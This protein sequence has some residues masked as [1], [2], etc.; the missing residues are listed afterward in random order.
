MQTI[1]VLLLPSVVIP[2]W[3]NMMK[4]MGQIV[5]IE[6]KR[7]HEE[8]VSKVEDASKLIF[9]ANSSANNLAT[10]LG[11]I[12]QDKQPSFSDIRTKVAWTLFE[13]QL[14]LPYSTQASYI[15]L[16]GHL[17]S[18]F[19]DGGKRYAMY[20][21][22]TFPSN[23]NTTDAYTWYTQSVN[24]NTGQ[25]Y[26]EAKTIKPLVVVEEPWFKRAMHSPNGYA[27]LGFQWGANKKGEPDLFLD[28]ARLGQTGVISLGFSVKEI[29]GLFSGMDL[30]DGSLYM[31]TL[32]DH[33]KVLLEEIKEAKIKINGDKAFILGDNNDIFGEIPCKSNND[34]TK[35]KGITLDVGGKSLVFSC[36]QIDIA[37]IPSAYVLAF[38]SQGLLSEVHQHTKAALV[39]LILMMVAMVISIFA[40]VALVVRAAR[41]EVQLCA[42]YMRQMEKTAQ[43]ERKTMKQS[44]AFASASHDIRGYIACIKSLIGLSFNHVHPSSPLASNLNNM[45]TCAQ[46]LLGLVNSI[47]DF[48]KIEAGKMQLEETEFDLSQ[49]LENMA[50]LH[51]LVAMKN[52][53]EV[54]L[55]PCDG[56][57]MKFSHVKGDALKLK[58][59]L[60]NLLSNAVKFTSQGHISIRAWAKKPSLENSIIASNKN[61]LLNWLLSKFSY[62]NKRAY[63]ELEGISTI[64]QDPNCLEFEFE[65]EDTGPGIPKE[66]RESIFENFV[67][68]KENSAGQVGTGL[69]LGIVQSYVR[70]M[71]GDIEVVDK[72][73]GERGTCFKFNIFLIV[74]DHKSPPNTP[75]Q[76]GTL[77]LQESTPTS[78]AR[79]PK[80]GGSVVVL[81]I[82]NEARQEMVKRYMESLG[83]KPIVLRQVNQLSRALKK[84]VKS[85]KVNAVDQCHDSSSERS[86]LPL[87]AMDG[88]D[89]ILPVYKKGKQARCITLIV[90]ANAGD[91]H[92]LR[93]SVAEFRKEHCR[94]CIKVVWLERPD[95]CGA[96]FPGLQDGS[97]PPTDCIISDPLHGSRL[98]RVI[99]LLPEFGGV[100]QRVP[101]IGRT[102]NAVLPY[103]LESE[104]EE[105]S[106]STGEIQEFVKKDHLSSF[107]KP[108]LGKEL[109]IVGSDKIIRAVTKGFLTSFGAS[110]DVCKSGEE[111]VELVHG[112]LHDRISG[113]STSRLPYDHILMEIEIEAM[114]GYEAAK[115]I[116]KEEDKYGMHIPIVGL[117]YDPSNGEGQRILEAGFDSYLDIPFTGNALL[118][119][120]RNAEKNASIAHESIGAEAREV[121]DNVEVLS[122]KNCLDGKRFLIVEDLQM[123]RNVA[124]SFLTHAGA[125]V[126]DCENGEA[127]F[128]LICKALKNMTVEDP[129]KFSYDCVL[130]DCQMPI[131]DGFEATRKIREEEKKYGIHIPIIALTADEGGEEV[132]KIVESGMDFHLT[133][134]LQIEELVQAMRI[135]HDKLDHVAY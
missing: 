73:N 130:M 45:T 75:R 94:A 117:N 128:E 110:V 111:A 32:R 103:N 5:E 99:R 84:M 33:G 95:T 87:S 17:F 115:L 4:R 44:L 135:I 77:E 30:R 26:G 105:M 21:N 90:D 64:K 91:F 107:G 8:I 20:S 100:I 46:D 34:A 10:F 54:I 1:A 41:R 42:A 63:S 96:H 129:S 19:I 14:M 49:L 36:S 39:L 53:V 112:A 126:E 9:P 11:S 28:T 81:L 71:G 89:E 59:I 123:L 18:Y 16:D 57:I 125:Y 37:R 47:L 93:R 132:K 116:R 72:A 85:N 13:A 121:R 127:A 131:M 68:V 106:N 109:L 134:P 56:S 88:L 51:Y 82:K 25:L 40:F 50:D 3:Y 31:A 70:L 120:L 65:V 61:S 7:D 119:A 6:A 22:S 52:G 35:S 48:S 98:S 38:R 83:L 92:E 24:P 15:G 102:S 12:F 27:S 79:G 66:K 78:C 104:T 108:L 101:S 86:S 122:S 133:K 74:Q 62:K 76:E 2:Y 60:G 69:G 55:D 29:I 80:L 67:Q 114:S 118:Q 58:Q 97:L 113:G 43:A 124:A 23:S